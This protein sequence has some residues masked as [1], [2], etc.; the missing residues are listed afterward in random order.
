MILILRK[1]KY[2]L[3]RIDLYFWGFGEKLNYFKGFGEQGKI[4]L[5]S[6]GKY[7]QGSGEINALFSGIKGAQTPPPPWGPLKSHFRH[8]NFNIFIF[9]AT[10]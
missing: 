10:L 8:L 5:G 1:E 6:R 3:G 4:I 9:C 2:F 7:F